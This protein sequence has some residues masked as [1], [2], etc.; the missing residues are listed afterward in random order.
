LS[1]DFYN[2]FSVFLDACI[3]AEI[4]VKYISSSKKYCF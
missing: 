2:Y 1:S 3:F 4:V